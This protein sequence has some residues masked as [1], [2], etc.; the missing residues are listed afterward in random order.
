M[1]GGGSCHVG[2]LSVTLMRLPMEKDTL[3]SFIDFAPHPMGSKRNAETT[4]T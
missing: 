2:R 4:G 3:L 1:D